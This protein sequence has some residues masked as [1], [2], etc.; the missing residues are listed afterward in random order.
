MNW[1]AKVIKEI[2]E[3]GYDAVVES[4]IPTELRFKVRESF[5]SLGE[6][7]ENISLLD[8]DVGVEYSIVRVSPHSN[9]KVSEE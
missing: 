1:K 8:L 7:L 2:V 9:Q 3:Y 4:D 6:M 5:D